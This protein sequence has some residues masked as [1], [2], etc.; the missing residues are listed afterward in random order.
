LRL[1]IAEKPS[2][3]RDLANILAAKPSRTPTHFVCGPDVVTYCVGHLLELF[4]P[5]EYGEHL[6]AWKFDTLPIV[7]AEWKLRPRAKRDRLNRVQRD[8]KR[9]PVPDPGLVS[10]IEA[11]R[12]LCSQASVV[13]NAGDPAREGQLIVDEVLDYVGNRQP[14]FRLLLNAM[15][16]E[17]IRRALASLR[18]NK[19]FFGLFMS[20]RARQRADWLIGMNATRACTIMGRKAGL[21]RVLSVGRVQTPTLAIVVK[22]DREI[23][24]FK[25]QAYF[26]IGADFAHQK[27]TYR[28]V[29][30]PDREGPG[31]D[32]EKRV[33]SE[34]LARSIAG[35]VQGKTGVV[36]K[37]DVK[38]ASE[39]PPLPYSL[40]ALQIDAGKKFGFS[41]KKVLDICQ[42]LY[43][44][45]KIASYPRTDT[46][47]LPESEF[48][49][50][51]RVLAS[52]SQ[53]S[54]EVERFARSA[55]TTRRSAAW[56]DQ[57]LTD[58]HGL[59]PV[60]NPNYAKLSAD[61][62]KV[63]DLICRAYVAQFYPPFDYKK[64]TVVTQVAGHHFHSS[65]RT[66]I[67]MGWKVI[68]GT[69]KEEA[70]SEKQKLPAM[71]EADPVKCTGSGAVPKQTK[72]PERYT[73]PTLLEAM[74]SVHKIVDDP[75]LKERLKEK[76][77]IGTPST[78][79][80]IIETLVRHAL[81]MRDGKKLISSESGRLLID[82]LPREVTDPATTALWENALEDISLNG[83][84]ID[85]F[86][87]RQAEWAKQIV[88]IAARTKIQVALPKVLG[89]GE[90]PYQGAA[91]PGCKTG[92]L[93]QRTAKKGPNAGKAFFGCSRYPD[94][95]HIEKI[96][97]Q[98][99]E[100]AA[101]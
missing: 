49:A 29:Y 7:P 82:V 25:P 51:P 13:V 47:Y 27:G 28:G 91:C 97:A 92:S 2:V 90:K 99:N 30:R 101:A 8:A 24:D 100:K 60:A 96:A 14:V 55:D 18:D 43:E 54:P 46:R 71:K 12:K 26:L 32:A 88:G 67:E 57:K 39:A 86:L 31:I 4:E 3:A 19:G 37:F 58:H 1:F 89:S 38:P 42:A 21:D 45:H 65:G 62:R 69:E 81:L 20:A 48:A 34:A 94:C 78:R 95:S 52:I 44:V 35:A 84:Q 61:E 15:N 56:N 98:G 11:I 36:A 87:K 22:R 79:A 93:R 6:R 50:A 33:I 83:G 73:D 76:K 16:D 17:S 72:P 41:A 70:D 80:A 63:F 53:F 10:Q 85:A 74:E 64:T 5:E 23:E 77:G 68:Y 59:M 66:P 40:T 9:I 75:A